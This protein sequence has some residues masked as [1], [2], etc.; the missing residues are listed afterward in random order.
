MTIKKFL[1]TV[2]LIIRMALKAVSDERRLA[3]LVYLLENGSKALDTIVEE[4]HISKKELKNKQIPALMRYGMI[5]NF[6]T[7]N[8]FDDEFCHYE[9]SNLG[10]KILNQLIS[11]V[12]IEKKSDKN[13]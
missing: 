7:A 6:Y 2:P 5:Y 1:E 13:T 4:L 8:S 10:R 9:I 3:I 12:V 11:M